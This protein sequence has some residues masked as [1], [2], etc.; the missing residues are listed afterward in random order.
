MNYLKQL[1]SKWLSIAKIIGNFNGQVILTV[2]YLT[3]VAPL[4]IIYRLLADPLEIKRGF[5]IKQKSSF[6]KWEHPKDNLEN[7]RRQY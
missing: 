5:I 4:G 2:F 6:R 7:A 1:W 3:L